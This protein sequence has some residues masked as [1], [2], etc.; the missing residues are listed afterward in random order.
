MSTLPLLLFLYV[1]IWLHLCLLGALL[2]HDDPPR[3]PSLS[4]G[5]PSSPVPLSTLVALLAGLLPLHSDAHL[6]I[7]IITSNYQMK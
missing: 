6:L 2:L 1:V 7:E 5:L 3:C 4:S